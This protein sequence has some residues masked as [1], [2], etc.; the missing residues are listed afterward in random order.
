LACPKTSSSWNSNCLFTTDGMKKPRFT[1]TASAS[2][3]IRGARLSDQA[4]LLRLIRAYY[5]FD[6]IRVR[7][8]SVERALQRLLQNRVHGRVWLML[9]NNK[10]I[11][12][13]VLTFNFDLEFS[14]LE[15]LVTDLFVIEKYRGRGLGKRALDAVDDYC[16]NRGIVTV[17][18]QVTSENTEAVAFYRRIGFEQLSR[19]VM[20]R[21][22]RPKN[23]FGSLQQTRKTKSFPYVAARQDS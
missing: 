12:Y 1:Q 10:A 6:G 13:V 14:G 15:G 11:G 16:R 17:E 2:I 5:R 21:D 18:L 8:A 22:I 4:D 9:D 19:V 3:V 20:T 7:L 23:S